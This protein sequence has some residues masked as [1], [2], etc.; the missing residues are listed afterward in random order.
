MIEFWMVGAAA[1]G[2]LT[3]AYLVIAFHILLG[4]ARAGHWRANPLGLAT[5]LIFFTCGVGHGEHFA[6]IILPSFGL[7]QE[8]GA[9]ARAAFA[10]WH[11]SL[12]DALTAAVA[13]WYFSLRGRFPAL[14]RG[15]AL[16]EDIR[17]RRREALDIHDN[18]VQG[19]AVAKLALDLGHV[20]QAAV[21]VERTLAASR[22]I[23]TDL[24]GDADS[25]VAFRPG[26]FRRTMQADR[27]K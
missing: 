3:A 20:E 23:I 25:E 1:N 21:A 2:A 10:N 12:W 9:A 18:V 22:K 19:L 13:L 6:H 15:S 24:L 17:V 26:D 5:G 14:I 4:V 8:A 16:F 27:A 11:V 7:E